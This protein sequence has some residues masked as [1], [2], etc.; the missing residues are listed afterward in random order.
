MEE[1]R[2]VVNLIKEKGLYPEIK[3]VC[4]S[5]KPEVIIDGKKY[6]L[7]CSNNYLGLSTNKNVTNAAIKAIKKYGLSPCSARLMSGTSDIHEKL[8]RKIAEFKKT[9]SAIVFSTGY[10]V[11]LGIIPAM[12]N[13]LDKWQQALGINKK[14]D[15][16]LIISDE[17]NHA[18]I[19]D[20]CHLANVDKAI[21]RH[22]DLKELEKIL[23]DNKN[24]RN[25]LIITESVFSL[26]GDIAPL[27]EIVSLARKYNALIMLDEAHG[28]GI[29]G[30]HGHGLAE[31]FGLEKE[32]DIK[33]GTFSKTLGG[34]GGFIASSKDLVDFLRISARSYIFTAS[35]AF[36]M[37]AGVNA[38]IEEIEKHP[39]LREKLW[40]NINYTRNG[41][42]R[43]GFDT[44]ES[45]SQIIPILIGDE[46]M[47]IEMAKLLFEEGIFALCVRYTAVPLG[48]ARIRFSLM[49]THTKKQIDYLLNK[50]EKV[51]KKLEII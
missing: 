3:T 14:L 42:K 46:K 25:K 33:M 12:F 40:D 51:G 35:P 29:F 43:L 13:G 47:A 4:S 10:T 9:E 32:I 15:K 17:L 28:T 22:K 16:G 20:G 21:Y 27:P 31:H 34:V 19:I 11:N 6:L 44:M 39:E 24:N 23:K 36:A 50:L 49:S 48:K 38:A 45:E 8:E 30:K 2:H 5:P 37:M 7:F 18:C 41:F 26:D 1:I